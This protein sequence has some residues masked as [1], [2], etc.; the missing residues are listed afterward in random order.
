MSLGDFFKS[1]AIDTW[2]K[3]LVYIGGIVLVL[4]FFIEVKGISN[5]QLQLIS[6]GVFILGLGEWKNHKFLPM[7]KPPNAYTGPA[8]FMNV[9]VWKPD[10]VGLLLDL[11]G[12]ALVVAGARAIILSQ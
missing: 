11:A 1:L 12:I 4:S 2:Y 3:A 10:P 8:M 6:G 5:S 9:P 7:I